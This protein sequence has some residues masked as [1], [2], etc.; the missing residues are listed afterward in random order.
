[1]KCYIPLPSNSTGKKQRLSDMVIDYSLAD[2]MILLKEVEANGRN[3]YA[4][5]I[6]NEAL[7][8]QGKSIRF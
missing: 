2:M 8:R 5:S 3:E 4:R 1:M 6:L 7:E